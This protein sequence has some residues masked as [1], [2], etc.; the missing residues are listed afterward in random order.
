MYSSTVTIIDVSNRLFDIGAWFVYA[1]LALIAILAIGPSR[2]LL[3][4]AIFG[5]PTKGSSKL[6]VDKK[7]PAHSSEEWLPEHVKTSIK[8]SKQRRPS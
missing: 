1:L 5:K 6:R 3:L 8:N 2:R 4:E 7:L